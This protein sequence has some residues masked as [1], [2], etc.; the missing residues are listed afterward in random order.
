M[1]SFGDTGLPDEQQ[2]ALRK[3][4]RL[5]VVGLVYLT[6]CVIVVAAVM[7]SS[8][9]MKVAWVEDMLS[10]IPPIAFILAARYTRRRPTSEHPYGF[11]RAV[12]SAH[13]A[14]AVALLTMGI[15]LIVD[16]ASGLIAAEHPPIGTMHLFG[17][18]VWAGWV[19]IAAMVY[20]GI[21]PVIL[22]HLKMPLSE[23]LHDKVLYADSDMNKAD[24]AT[25]L[26]AILGILGIGIGWWWADA[27]AA[28]AIASTV[29]HDGVT[30][31]RNATRG[32]MDGRAR[33]FDDS[34]P[35]PLIREVERLVASQAWV[36]DCGVRIRDEGHL[37]HTEIFFVPR[38]P[39]PPVSELHRLR[40]A[41]DDLDWK[42]HDVVIAPVETLPPHLRD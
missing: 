21:G 17:H 30:Q 3:A 39:M 31:I 28:L 41:V 35:H 11:H 1:T 19:M 42:L 33:R 40:R 4:I 22:G 26:G 12:G 16:S 10:L 7:G 32:L 23:K 27:V 9:A 15:F 29:V 38:G 36:A 8:Q 5:E 34:A 6:S 14:A 18:T 25:A 24:W 37:F 13:L 20:T 2:H